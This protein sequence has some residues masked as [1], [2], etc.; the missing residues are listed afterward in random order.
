MYSITT[1]LLE[2]MLLVLSITLSQQPADTS[3]MA[4]ITGFITSFLSH[5]EPESKQHLWKVW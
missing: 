5:W 2:I 4:F 3:L 1:L